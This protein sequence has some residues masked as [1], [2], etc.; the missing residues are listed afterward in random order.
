MSS[1]C[2]YAQERSYAN[3]VR[4][5]AVNRFPFDPHPALSHFVGEGKSLDRSNLRSTKAWRIK[6][7]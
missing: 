1:Y 3:R 2:F 5:L 4:R 6:S 7:Y